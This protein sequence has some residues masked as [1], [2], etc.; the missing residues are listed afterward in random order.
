MGADQLRG[1]YVA[2]QCLYVRYIDSIIPLLPKS[3]FSSLYPSS[4][5]VQSSL[6]RTKLETK[7]ER[8]RLCVCC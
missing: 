7:R 8:A 3:E 6:C 2:D 1:Y 4:V 5:A